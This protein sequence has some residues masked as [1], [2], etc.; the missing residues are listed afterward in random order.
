MKHVFAEG[1]WCIGLE[2]LYEF[3]KCHSHVGYEER[4]L[5]RRGFAGYYPSGAARHDAEPRRTDR[6]QRR[7]CRTY[8]GA[9]FARRAVEPMLQAVH[10]G[11]FRH[12]Q[13]SP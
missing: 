13:K 7:Y 3:R 4:Y 5:S 1:S 11:I 9:T 6:Y 12:T 10:Q 8:T 2:F